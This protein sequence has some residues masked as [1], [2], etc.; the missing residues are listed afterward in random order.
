MKERR[1]DKSTDRRVSKSPRRSVSAF[2]RPPVPPSQALPLITLLTDFGTADYFVGAVKGVIL[3]A[4]PE[5]R[6][7]DLTHE[8]PAHDIAAAAFTLLAAYKSFPGNSVHVA[9]VDPGVGSSRRGI[10]VEA[11]DRLFVGPDNG[12][13][14]YILERE[15]AFRIFELTKQKYFREPASPSFHGRDV[16]APVA[17]ALANGLKASRLGAEIADPVRLESLEPEVISGKSAL[18]AGK[19]SSAKVRGRI[20]HIDHFGN[21]VTNITPKVLTPEMI[22]DGAHLVVKGK[23]ITSFRKFFAEI[24]GSRLELFCIWGSAGFLEIAAANR[25][26]AKLLKTHRGQEVVVGLKGGHR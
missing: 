25:S 17:A 14:S 4:N 23:K 19:S 9:V 24:P 6:I 12:I 3:S 26:A 18:R 16:F 11:A 10:V 22:A 20:I 1:G 8:I 15:P 7:V 2:P 5:A 21:C 13:F